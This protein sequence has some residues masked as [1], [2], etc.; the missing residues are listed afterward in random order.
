MMEIRQEEESRLDFQQMLKDLESEGT[1][2]VLRDVRQGDIEQLFR[3]K[4]GNA[5][6]GEPR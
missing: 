1:Q 2:P 3:K 4:S 6:D 5:R